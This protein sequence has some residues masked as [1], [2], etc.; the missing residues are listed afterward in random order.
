M[1]PRPM[2]WH[3][4]ADPGRS[5]DA[6]L[7][8]G[9]APRRQRDDEI[10]LEHLAD[11]LKRSGNA[12]PGPGAAL[13]G[14]LAQIAEQACLATA[15]TGAAI[16]LKQGEEFVCCASWGTQAPPSGIHLST[17]SGLSGTCVRE[18][19][20]QRCDDTET[21]PR[22]DAIA[23]RQ[24]Q[25]RSLL[26]LPLLK[27]EELLG[28]F[29]VL[30][31]HA[32]AFG[33]RDF[34]TLNTLC[35]RIIEEL[36]PPA[37]QAEALAPPT[38]VSSSQVLLPAT[39]APPPKQ[40]PEE[41]APAFVPS[42][43]AALPVP[44]EATSAKSNPAAEEPPSAT[45]TMPASATQNKITVT[46]PALEAPSPLRPQPL[47]LENR[48][49]S[50]KTP[51]RPRDRTAGVLVALVIALAVLLGWMIGHFGWQHKIA[52]ETAKNLAPA[53]QHAVSPATKAAGTAR[54]SS[55]S[56]AVLAAP[57]PAAP[58]TADKAHPASPPSLAGIPRKTATPEAGAPSGGLVVYQDGKV[59]FRQAS[60]PV[61]GLPRRGATA[62]T[63]ASTAVLSPEQASAR[64]T[65]RVEPHYPD[66]ARKQHI[67]GPVVFDIWVGKDGT[68]Q[69]L[70]SFGGN[71]ALLDAAAE[72]VRQWRF[73][74]YVR[75]GKAVEF[76]TRVTVNFVLQGNP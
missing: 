49:L 57:A 69:Q 26:V 40:E 63:P 8:S 35:K 44:T 64:L 51:D 70:R 45:R 76:T 60:P 47:W 74:P 2:M 28:I 6:P 72:A 34:E 17:D 59:I 25:V 39:A 46:S 32:R 54:N 23:C 61:G 29:E 38:G 9:A 16:A 56:H 14:K 27:G 67:Q 22:V 13:R 41:E 30:S 62:A 52:A 20:A 31:S 37:P 15:A 33:L 71:H 53:M 65:Y 75:E 24:L 7:S 18:R 43:P 4:P 36:E 11:L 42:P 66:L 58:S 19:Q 48:P 68:V 3:D 73:R 21:D 10:P 5:A 50:A 1:A 12:L 55:L